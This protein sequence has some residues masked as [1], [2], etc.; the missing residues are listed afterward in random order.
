MITIFGYRAPDTDVE[1][2]QLLKEAFTEYLPAQ[3]FSHID[4]IERPNFNYD[5]LS[6]IWREFARITN[7]NFCIYDS[8]YNSYL[9]KSPRRTVEC[10]C[11]RNKGWWGR[12]EIV[13]E[14]KDSWTD[15]QRKLSPLLYE[16]NLVKRCW[17]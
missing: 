9:A 4:I 12:S 2:A 17:K 14:E 15:V 5:E 6:Q 1:A 11:K 16:E 13:L 8:F 7:D 10:L 3:R